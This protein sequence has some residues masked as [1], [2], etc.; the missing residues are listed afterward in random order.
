M[1]KING[2]YKK[3]ALA[4]RK[5]VVKECFGAQVVLQEL[6]VEQPVSFIQKYMQN[7]TQSPSFVGHSS[8]PRR[9][10][11]SGEARINF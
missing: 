4:I 1:K 10:G 9:T 7:Q 8:R 6:V 3:F 2:L 11:A 5:N